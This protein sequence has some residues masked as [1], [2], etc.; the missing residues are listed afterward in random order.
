MCSLRRTRG[1]GSKDP[2]EKTP[3]LL[4]WLFEQRPPVEVKQVEDFVDEG[5]RRRGRS[6]ALDPR[7]EEREVG[8]AVVVH[9]DHLA[10]DDAGTRIEP[11]RRVEEGPEV[12]AGV[13]LATRPQSDA[14]VVHD[15]LH[16]EAVPFHLEQPVRIVE[17]RTDQRREHRRDEARR[18]LIRHRVTL[19]GS[20]P[21]TSQACGCTGPFSR[22]AHTLESRGGGL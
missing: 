4:E 6:P 14:A 17:R 21:A 18:R 22:G 13:L 5:C 12:A 15:G 19:G 7:L 1:S 8:L 20:A 11:G 10:V 16:P 2:A 3:A 9:G